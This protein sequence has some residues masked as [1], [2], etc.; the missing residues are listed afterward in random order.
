MLLPCLAAV[1]DRHNLRC[2][3]ATTRH[4]VCHHFAITHFLY[5]SKATEH[6]TLQGALMMESIRSDTLIQRHV[7]SRLQC[8]P[9]L[10]AMHQSMGPQ[11]VHSIGLKGV[12][13]S[14]MQTCGADL[15][16]QLVALMQACLYILKVGTAATMRV[17]S[18]TYLSHG[19]VFFTTSPHG[20][21]HPKS[22]SRVYSGPPGGT[23]R[24]AVNVS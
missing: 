16:A 23:R 20:H 18:S 13:P 10:F 7:G 12:R 17:T 11:V 21:L 4:N 24:L 6:V 19:N 9:P 8:G 22:L 3:V 5:A 2:F 14:R 15:R 1:R